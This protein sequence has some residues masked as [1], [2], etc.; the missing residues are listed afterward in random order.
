MIP[1]VAINTVPRMTTTSPCPRD[2]YAIAVAQPSAA[3][4]KN[5]QGCSPWSVVFAIVL[6]VTA[7]GSRLGAEARSARVEGSGPAEAGRPVHRWL[8]PGGTWRPP[9]GGPL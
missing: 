6:D 4:T 8:P 9:L 1:A 7:A 3:S 5:C 2:R